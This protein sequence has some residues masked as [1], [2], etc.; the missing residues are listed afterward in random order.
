M[1][2]PDGRL[3]YTSKLIGRRRERTSRE[4]LSRLVSS[5]DPYGLYTS[6]EL[7]LC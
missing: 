2:Y 5:L 4:E 3:V 7:R 1:R 6:E